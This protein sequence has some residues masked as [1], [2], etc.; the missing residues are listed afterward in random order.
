MLDRSQPCLVC[1]CLPRCATFSSRNWAEKSLI[2][3][4]RELCQD[5]T[6][7]PQSS[8][9]G[10]M[11]VPPCKLQNRTTL[12]YIHHHPPL[13]V[14]SVCS[15]LS[16]LTLKTLIGKN[17]SKNAANSMCVCVK[18]FIHFIQ[19]IF[20]LES[21]EF[22]PLLSHVGHLRGRPSDRTMESHMLRG[23]FEEDVI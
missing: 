7:D 11:S 16:S 20:F 22:E 23:L 4:S 5:P 10:L 13:H 2:L 3:F 12:T 17:S 18:C 21:S 15:N 9:Q 6:V 8:I 1:I 14:G 19:L